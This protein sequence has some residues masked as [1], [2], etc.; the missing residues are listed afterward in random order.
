MNLNWLSLIPSLVLPSAV[1]SFQYRDLIPVLHFWELFYTGHSD[2][3]T[4]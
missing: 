3:A 4:I 1:S 2:F